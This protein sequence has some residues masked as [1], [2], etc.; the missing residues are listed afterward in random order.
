MVK[1]TR[2]FWVTTTGVCLLIVILITVSSI[3]AQGDSDNPYPIIADGNIRQ[4]QSVQTLNFANIE[5][6]IVPAS[7]LF[8]ASADGSKIATFGN[9]VGDPPLS[10]AIL[11]G[12]GDT[13]NAFPMVNAIDDSS[14]VRLL[15][16][17]GRCLYAGYRGY[18]H[19]WEFDPISAS[20]HSIQI[21]E[22]DS[23]DEMVVGLWLAE[24][25]S[26]NESCNL[27][28]Y[29]EVMNSTGE[30]FILAPD[31]SILHENIFALPDSED[32]AARVGRVPE[33]LALTMDFDGTL[34][35]WDMQSQTVTDTIPLGELAM[36]G[37]VN[38]SGT[39]YVWLQ[40][41]YAGLHLVDFAAAEDR[42]VA[43]FDSAYI[44]HLKL[45]QN[46]DVVIGVDPRDFPGTVSA[47]LVE[48]GERINL[49]DYRECDRVQPDLVQL[50]RDGTTLIIGC[51]LG[52]DVW[53]IVEDD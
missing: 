1:L 50:S 31:L 17:D 48:S 25:H 2:F 47:W 43:T 28:V 13:E 29:A 44:S 36:F 40:S 18:Y 6:G 33:P 21:A 11:W 37:A 51:D 41:N 10:Q 7:G 27:N 42:V 26:E 30:S 46:A 52:I 12:Y 19:I 45:S 39:H 14:L 5:D 53:R 15:S 34:Y 3:A 38:T 16:D 35:R 9:L 8:V 49:G 23:P 24:D 20:L 22:L 4:L 32:A